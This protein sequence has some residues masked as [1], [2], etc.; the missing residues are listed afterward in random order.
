MAEAFQNRLTIGPR[1][2]SGV[3]DHATHTGGTI[4]GAGIVNP[5][6]RG[7]AP[8]V[9]LISYG[10][11]QQGGLHQGFLYNDPCDIQLDFAE[12]INMFH[13]DIDSSSIGTNTATNG[14]PCDWEGDYGV[15]DV[16]L[17]QIDQVALDG[18]AEERPVAGV[19]RRLGLLGERPV[20]VGCLGLPGDDGRDRGEPDH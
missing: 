15:T 8:G 10:I 7:M 14:F 5:L 20:A 11:E 17:D 2:T 18:A 13:A 16:L 12:A 1:D 4:G 3:I 19:R 6:Y 9:H